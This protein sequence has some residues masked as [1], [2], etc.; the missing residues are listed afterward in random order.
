M[1]LINLV[2]FKIRINNAYSYTKHLQTVYEYLNKTS[3]LVI[4]SYI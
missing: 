4:K 1:K 2:G 3:N